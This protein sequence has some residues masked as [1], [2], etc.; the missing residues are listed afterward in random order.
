M[1][2]VST[3]ESLFGTKLE[4]QF[5]LAAG[6]ALIGTEEGPFAL[7]SEDDNNIVV[8]GGTKAVRHASFKTVCSGVPLEMAKDLG[9]C[10]RVLDGRVVCEIGP[11]TESG[12]DYLEALLRALVAYLNAEPKIETVKPG[13]TPAFHGCS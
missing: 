12:S 8:F 11:I 13:Y 1:S 7:F 2:I 3:A 9:A 10:L 5:A 6:L 4:Y